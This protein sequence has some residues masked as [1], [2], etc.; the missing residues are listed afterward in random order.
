MSIQIDK[1]LIEVKPGSFIYE[2]QNSLSEVIRKATK[3]E[4]IVGTSVIINIE[5]Y[6]KGKHICIVDVKP[7][8][9]TW[10]DMKS[11]DGGKPAKEIFFVRAGPETKRLSPETAHDW[12]IENV[13]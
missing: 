3:N 8:K 10:V 1:R 5:E 2:F 4:A 11:I 13:E 7:K 6:E 12:R 9:W